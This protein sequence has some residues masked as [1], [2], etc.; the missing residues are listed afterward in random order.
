[1]IRL[2]TACADL[3]VGQHAVGIVGVEYRDDIKFA[4]AD[5]I[6]IPCDGAQEARKGGWETVYFENAKPMPRL[7]LDLLK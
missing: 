2:G 6:R 1:M 5:Q 4:A 3:K 7:V